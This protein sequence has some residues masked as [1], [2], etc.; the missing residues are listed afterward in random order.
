MD[1]SAVL[2]P[3]GSKVFGEYSSGIELGQETHSDRV[4]ADSH[5]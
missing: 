1:G 4:D 3:G 5:A 2:I